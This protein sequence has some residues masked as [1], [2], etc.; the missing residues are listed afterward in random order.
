[1]VFRLERVHNVKELRDQTF[2]QAMTQRAYGACAGEI[3]RA[4]R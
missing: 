4:W 1:M 2:L 3:V